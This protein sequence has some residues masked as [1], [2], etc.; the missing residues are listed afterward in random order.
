MSELIDIKDLKNQKRFVDPRVSPEK[1]TEFLADPPPNLEI[2]SLI[3][4]YRLD[5]DGKR[6]RRVCGMPRSTKLPT[7]VPEGIDNPHTVKNPRDEYRC[8]L[9]AGHN[10]SHLGLGPCFRHQWYA[11]KNFRGH[12]FE[13]GYHLKSQFE[14]L[15]KNEFLK[16]NTMQEKDIAIRPETGISNPINFEYYID[17]AKEKYTPEDLFD[18][19]RYLYELEAV[20][21]AIKEQMAEDGVDVGSLEMMAD[22]ILKSADFQQKMA[23]RDADLMQASHMQL[24]TKA[25]VT[26]LIHIVN[27]TL[28]AEKAIEVLKKVKSDLVLPVNEIGATELIRRQQAAGISDKVGQI[29]DTVEAD[30]KDVD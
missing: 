12:K 9:Y 19:V 13:R 15:V 4:I 22:Q 29:A 26:G 8:Q 27:E 10:T 23:K 18:S 3:E 2:V 16:A 28:G 21:L 1:L 20:R 25:L 5:A 7:F 30:F 17:K 11:F 6:D 24:Q 14:D